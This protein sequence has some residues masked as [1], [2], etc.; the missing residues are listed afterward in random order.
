VSVSPGLSE[1]KSGAD[2]NFLVRPTSPT[3]GASALLADFAALNQSGLLP[4][5]TVL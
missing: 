1:A 2:I 3:F 5:P 4:T